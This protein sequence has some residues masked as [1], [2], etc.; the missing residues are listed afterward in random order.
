MEDK[1]IRPERLTPQQKEDL[2]PKLETAQE[3]FSMGVPFTEINEKLDLGFPCDFAG[4][5]EPWAGKP[6]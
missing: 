3:L 2:E 6:E 5:D 4:A 1:Q